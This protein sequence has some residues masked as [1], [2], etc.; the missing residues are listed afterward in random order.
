MSIFAEILHFGLRPTFWSGLFLKWH[1]PTLFAIPSPHYPLKEHKCARYHSDLRC[2]EFLVDFVK[3]VSRKDKK[4]CYLFFPFCFSEL[5]E[6]ETY[7]FRIKSTGIESMD[8]ELSNAGLGLI[9]FHRSSK[10]ELSKV[11]DHEF[12]KDFLVN[13]LMDSQ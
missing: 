10:N 11:G 2:L 5:S 6:P 8:I 3:D 4:S 7:P 12:C 13:S 1:V 9:K